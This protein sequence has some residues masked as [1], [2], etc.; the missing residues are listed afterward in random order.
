MFNPK[1]LHELVNNLYEGEP[2]VIR[3]HELKQLLEDDTNKGNFW[4]K[5]LEKHMLFT[6][7]KPRNTWYMD[8]DDGTD[9]KF[10]TAIRYNNRN[11]TY[12]ATINSEN[13]TGWLRVCLVAPGIEFRHVYFMLIP[14]NYHTE[15]TSP[16]KV[17]FR[18]NTA[19]IGEAWDRYR[20]SFQDVIKPIVDIN[21][22]VDNKLKV[23][24]TDEY[25]LLVESNE[26][27]TY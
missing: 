13:K 19:P 12:Q 22:R 3:S 5:V 7:R 16:L 2:E 11:G 8:F 14:P 6:K 23:V 24:Y 20:C 27:H 26:I 21:V 10:A 25:Q 9:A 18:N 1:F 4:E 15:L 17:T